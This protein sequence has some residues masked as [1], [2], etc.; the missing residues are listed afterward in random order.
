MG[1]AA[2]AEATTKE[3]AAAASTTPVELCADCVATGDD[4]EPLPATMLCQG[5]KGAKGADRYLCSE[6]AP[7]HTRRGHAS[8]LPLK[9]DCV[10]AA[11]PSNC[12]LHPGNPL[13]RVCLTE[14]VAVCAECCLVDHPIGKH[15]VHMI[16]KAT[17]MLQGRLER[18]TPALQRGSVGLALLFDDA[19]TAGPRQPRCA[20]SMMQCLHLIVR[21]TTRLLR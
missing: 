1:L 12:P 21:L 7:A 3:D 17:D 10:A 19:T 8:V 2:F 6:H 11:S 14:N 16:D 15:D 5:C 9:A 18:L 13:S 20:T 4:E